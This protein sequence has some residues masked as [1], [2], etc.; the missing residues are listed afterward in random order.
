MGKKKVYLSLQSLKDELDLSYVPWAEK[1]CW[2]SLEV[3]FDPSFKQNDLK[4]VIAPETKYSPKDEFF[5]F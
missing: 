4:K 5:L 3:C 1:A 2:V